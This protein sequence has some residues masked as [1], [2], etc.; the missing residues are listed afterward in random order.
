[1]ETSKKKTKLQKTIGRIAKVRKKIKWYPTPEE[2]K[3][4]INH[5]QKY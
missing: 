4:M 2:I 1:M 3:E 5:G